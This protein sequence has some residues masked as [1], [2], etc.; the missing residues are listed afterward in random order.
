MIHEASLL[1]KKQAKRLKESTVRL[2]SLT[3][4]NLYQ[5]T[6]VTDRMYQLYAFLLVSVACVLLWQMTLVYIESIFFSMTPSVS[7]FVLRIVVSMLVLLLCALS[8]KSV[9]TGP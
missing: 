9:R 2:F 8:L 6:S 3:G 7:V 4:S 5:D 1:A